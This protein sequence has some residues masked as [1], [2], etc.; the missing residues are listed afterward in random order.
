MR[1]GDAPTRH[2]LELDAWVRRVEERRELMEMLGRCVLEVGEDLASEIEEL[3]E[4]CGVEE[5]RRVR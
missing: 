5:P 3:L 4:R 1:A 2:E